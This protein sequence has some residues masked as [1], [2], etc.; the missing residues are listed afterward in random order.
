LLLGWF[1][2]LLIRLIET[3]TQQTWHQVMRTVRPLSVAY[4]HSPYGTVTQTNR[5]SNRQKSVP[6]A[7]DIK[8]P[9]RFLQLP[10]PAK[11]S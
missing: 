3:Q 1:A 2:L 7:L 5:V 6:D 10:T 4:Q 11:A 9:E 8:P